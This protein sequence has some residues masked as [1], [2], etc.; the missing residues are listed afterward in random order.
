VLLDA[1]LLA[2]DIDY[3]PHAKSFLI[4]GVLE[5]KIVRVT[6]GGKATDFAKSPSGWPML[7]VKV[8]AGW[9]QVRGVERLGTV[10]GALL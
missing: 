7:A 5:K 9:F 3:D 2:E 6:Q 8:D 1:N 4:S 10:G